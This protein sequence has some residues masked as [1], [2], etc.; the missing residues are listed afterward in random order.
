[1]RF[2]FFRLRSEYTSPL[3]LHSLGLRQVQCIYGV[4]LVHTVVQKVQNRNAGFKEKQ[5]GCFVYSSPSFRNVGRRITS[6]QRL[7]ASPFSLLLW[8]C[9]SLPRLET[10]SEK[11]VSSFV[12]GYTIWYYVTNNN[13]VWTVHSS[14]QQLRWTFLPKQFQV[15]NAGSPRV[16]HWNSYDLNT[17][18]VRPELWRIAMNRPKEPTG[19]SSR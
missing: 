4:N 5:E 7:G 1:M 15:T 16:R 14:Q 2:R 18:T 13:N 9:V 3:H 17:E 10:R 12:Y 8:V 6:E 11:Y 19:T